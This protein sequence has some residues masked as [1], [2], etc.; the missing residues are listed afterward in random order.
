V[1][2][3]ISDY[4]FEKHEAG[5]I[6]EG[7]ELLPVFGDVSAFINLKSPKR[8]VSTANMIGKRVSLA[9]GITG[10]AWFCSTKRL[11]PSYPQVCMVLLRNRET[12]ESV[13]AMWIDLT[14]ERAE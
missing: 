9:I 1:L 10:I 2:A 3:F 13:S 5:L 4:L 11:N 7:L 12:T 8:E 6:A 14:L